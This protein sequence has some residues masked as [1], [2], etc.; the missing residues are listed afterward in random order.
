MKENSNP[1]K[2][3]NTGRQ[4]RHFWSAF[5]LWLRLLV[6]SF[7]RNK[8]ELEG[9][10]FH[11][12][13]PAFLN[14]MHLAN[15]PTPSLK[16]K[17]MPHT[18]S[19][20]LL[21]KWGLMLL[22]TAFGTNAIAQAPPPTPGDHSVCINTTKEYGVVLTTGSTYAWSITPNTGFTLTPH[23]T[24]PNLITV[25]WTAVGV[26][27]VRVVETNAEG[28]VGDTVS[29]VV[30]V[31]PLPT[32]VV[33]SSTVCEG[34]A[35]TITATPGEPGTY[36]YAW[37]VPAGVPDPGNVASFTSTVAGTYSVV[38]INT[39]TGCVSASASGTVTVNPLPVCSIT[40]NNNV[41][42]GT[43]N[44]Y[45][46]PLGMS[47]YSWSIS[48]NATISGATNGQTVSVLTNNSCG[49]FTL[50]LT[51]IDTNGCTS[52]CNQTFDITQP[53]FTYNQPADTTVA[54]CTFADQASLNAAIAAWVTQRTSAIAATGGC[55]PQVTSNFTNQSINLCDGGN[56]TITWT[57]TDK[58]DTTTV[59]AIY[60][61][62]PAPALAFNQPADTTVAACTFADQASL[63]AAIA[64][65]VTQRTGAIAATGGCAPQVTS[66]FTNQSINLCDGGNI[67]ITWTI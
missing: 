4:A 6:L 20:K 44:T 15:I 65:W 32:V 38:I 22:F 64:A 59:D 23:P 12:R 5:L 30:T 45:S 1:Y 17:K 16:N 36:S 14:K 57:I 26:Y 61:V 29:I 50:N 66:N 2:T 67:T 62:T 42:P 63:N 55:A 60:T 28:C 43:T 13:V 40:G 37:T 21:I 46:G 51:I 35:A 41:C 33:N 3:K 18:H 58:C 27:T 9:I 34:I 11:E 10:F 31:N 24:Y 49:S 7:T 25:T 56:I 48:G 47:T 39:A 8:E 53:P 19:A 52:T 54:A